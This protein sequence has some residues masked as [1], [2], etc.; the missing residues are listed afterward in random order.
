MRSTRRFP[1]GFLW[2]AATA[3]YQIEGAVSEDGRGASI[4][5]TFSHTPGRIRHEHTGDV[6]C[7][8]YHRWREDLDLA[9]SLGLGAYRFSIA[10]PRVIPNGDGAVNLRGLDF[11]DRLVDGLLERGIAPVATLY[12]WDLPQALQDRG[13]WTSRAS[14]DAFA[15]YAEVVAERLG[16]RVSMW[17]TLNEPWVSAFVGHAI[18]RHAPGLRDPRS[19]IQAAHHLLLAHARALE[20][21]RATAGPVGI[22][23]NVT[24][25]VPASDSPED[26]MA[27]ALADQQVNGWFL[28]PLR[29]GRYPGDMARAYGSLLDGIVEAGDLEAIAAP[30]DFLG[31]NYYTRTHVAAGPPATDADDPMRLL[32]YRSVLPDGPSR[33]AMDWPVEPDGLRAFVGRLAR[34]DPGLPIQVTEN[35]SAWD[36]AVA[37]DGSVT[38]PERVEYL[39]SHLAA[40]H[41]AIADGARVEGYFAWS[42]LDNFEWAEGYTKRF[43]LIHVDYATQRRVPK[44]SARRYAEIVA[45]NGL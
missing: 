37:P 45:A 13:G 12:H 33:T 23:L 34:E 7:D 44:A 32:P 18:G 21:L 6:A 19:A 27:A 20:P 25:V 22:A 9:A 5:D 36:D 24:E 15:R 4:W 40:L 1:D 10:W 8:H 26:A 31:I 11:Y 43:G 29:R 38:D 2:G 28:E 16:D 17:I 35:G 42:L 41:D 14:A 3:S 39:E 30:I